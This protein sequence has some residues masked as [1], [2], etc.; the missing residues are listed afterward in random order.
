MKAKPGYSL[1]QGYTSI[2]EAGNLLAVFGAALAGVV[3]HW[4]YD[5]LIT[6]LQ[7]TPQTFQFGAVVVVVARLIVSIIATLLA[8][9]GI[10]QQV[11]S[12]DIKV[13]FFLAFSQG[14]ALDA[15]AGTAIMALGS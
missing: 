3:A 8:F 12:A 15:F 11:Q 2:S 7:A 14:F 1:M 10:Y 13:R 9:V 6:G 4:I 5:V